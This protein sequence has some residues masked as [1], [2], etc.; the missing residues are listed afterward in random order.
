LGFKTSTEIVVKLNQSSVQFF[1]PK[2]S[3]YLIALCALSMVHGFS[4]ADS[5]SDVRLLIKTGKSQEALNKINQE[6]SA[7]PKDPQFRFLKGVVLTDTG[8]VQEAISTFNKLTEDYP[9]LPEPY[10]N[11]ASLYAATGQYD[12]ARAA[13]ETAIRTNPSYSVAHENLGDIYALLAGQAYSKAL[14]LDVNKTQAQ[15]KLVLIRDIVSVS[16]LTPGL[17][18]VPAPVAPINNAQSTTV[19]ASTKPTSV[20]T[21]LTSQTST[22]VKPSNTQVAVNNKPVS[23]PDANSNTAAIKQAETAVLAWAKAW[24][25]QDINEYLNSYSKDYVP[26]S[27]GSHKA[28]EEDRK[29]KILGKSKISVSLSGINTSLADNGNTAIVKFRQNYS[30]GALQTSTR[31]TL[32]LSKLNGRWVI[33]KEISG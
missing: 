20:T 3:I 15:P 7:K 28:W 1:Q 9:R 32:Q 27:G 21:P 19:V 26:A 23:P 10:N 14:Q 13:L 31:K 18:P 2:K 22:V 8:R 30:A 6:L 11:L 33:V 12:R 5:L 17:A 25:S 4:L 24:S 29:V 16:G